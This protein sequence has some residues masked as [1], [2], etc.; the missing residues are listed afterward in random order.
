MVAH[1]YAA[2]RQMNGKPCLRGAVHG[3]DFGS[4]QLSHVEEEMAVPKDRAR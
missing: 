2:A 1:D 3:W 4:A